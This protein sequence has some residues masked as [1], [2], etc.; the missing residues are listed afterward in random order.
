VAAVSA[1]V[2]SVVT[3]VAV[4]GD[5]AAAPVPPQPGSAATDCRGAALQCV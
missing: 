2:G 1:A 4:A 3:Y 5:H